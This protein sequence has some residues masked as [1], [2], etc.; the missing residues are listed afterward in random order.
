MSAPQE[1]SHVTSFTS[2]M[3]ARASS[4]MREKQPASSH[5]EDLLRRLELQPGGPWRSPSVKRPHIYR[6]TEPKQSYFRQ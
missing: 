4:D 2:A 1:I 5:P 6:E 3:V